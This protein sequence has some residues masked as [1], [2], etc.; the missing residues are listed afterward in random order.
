M[1]PVTLL[2]LMPLAVSAPVSLTVKLSLSA[3]PDRVPPFR[4]ATSML[5][6]S[7]SEVLR[8][9]PS[10]V[11]DV[12]DATNVDVPSATAVILSPSPEVLPPPSTLFT[13]LKRIPAAS[14][15]WSL[16]NSKLSD[17]LVPVSS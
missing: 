13:S 14:T 12:S 2:I 16:T 4:L 6:K 9:L 11:S 1:L 15:V 3:L 10:A 5:L 17:P 7:I 8:L